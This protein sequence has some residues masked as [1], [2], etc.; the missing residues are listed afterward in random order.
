MKW[1]RKQAAVRRATP[2]G[3]ARGTF[4]R[5]TVCPFRIAVAAASGSSDGRISFAAGARNC[6]AAPGG[7]AGAKCVR[8]FGGVVGAFD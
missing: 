4:C 1:E 7:A 6:A 2:A 3:D 8:R 5:F